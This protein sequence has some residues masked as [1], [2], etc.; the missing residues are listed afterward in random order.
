MRAAVDAAK[1][2]GKGL[3]GRGAA[4]VKAAVGTLSP[5]QRCTLRVASTVRTIFWR[6]Q[7]DR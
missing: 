4:G 1:E 3:G 7:L 5:I 2:T 6:E